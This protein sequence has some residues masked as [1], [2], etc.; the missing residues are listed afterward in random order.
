MKEE[1]RETYK[2][3]CSELVERFFPALQEASQNLAQLKAKI[4]DSVGQCLELK[5][6]VFGHAAFA[7]GHTASYL[8]GAFENTTDLLGRK[9]KEL[10][11]NKLSAWKKRTKVE[12]LT[13]NY[14]PGR[15]QGCCLEKVT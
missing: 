1:S 4:Y 10:V 7:H 5:A 6:E 3:L 8:M 2:Q 14:E 9:A 15:Q 11:S 12:C 13:S